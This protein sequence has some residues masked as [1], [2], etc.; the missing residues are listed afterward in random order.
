MKPFNADEV[1]E[2]IL[3]DIKNGVIKTTHSL[4]LIVENLSEKFDVKALLILVMF[5]EWLAKKNI[6]LSTEHGAVTISKMP[7]KN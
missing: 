3:I 5:R 1:F 7:D 4:R 2:P 6:D